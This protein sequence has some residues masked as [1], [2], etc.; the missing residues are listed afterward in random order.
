MESEFKEEDGRNLVLQRRLIRL[1]SGTRWPVEIH[2]H[3]K[4][5]IEELTIEKFFGSFQV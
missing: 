5:R 2:G 3:E 1:T 4:K